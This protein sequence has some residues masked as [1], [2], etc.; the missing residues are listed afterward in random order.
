MATIDKELLKRSMI[1][2]IENGVD[3][4]GQ[5]KYKT[6]TFNGIKEEASLENIHAVGTAVGGLLDAAVKDIEL[7][8]KSALN[9]Q[10]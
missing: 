6:K 9:E 5:T 10:E 8:E 7:S 3:E 4:N 1:I 2:N